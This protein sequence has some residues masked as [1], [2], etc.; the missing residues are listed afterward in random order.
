[1]FAFIEGKIDMIQPHYVVLDVGGIGYEIFI[2]LNTYGAIHKKEQV[3]LYIYYHKSDHGDALYGFMSNKEKAFFLQL[4]G[5][6][7]IGPSTAQ[8][9]L[10]TFIKGIGNKTA[11]RI[12]VDLR[13][14]IDIDSSSETIQELGGNLL[15][16][17]QEE[18]ISA[19]LSLGFNKAQINKALK[20]VM[21]TSD[22]GD[23]VEDLIREALHV[24]SN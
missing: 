18:V 17:S 1:M 2:N 19:L 21:Q 23:S 10:S 11:Q 22:I 15:L 14:K 7:K 4:I 16:R 20:Q 13:D 8:V 3:K 12:I 6:N 5:V 9:M 24:L